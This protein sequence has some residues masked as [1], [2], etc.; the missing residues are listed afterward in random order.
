MYRD[1]EKTVPRVMEKILHPL[2]SVKSEKLHLLR[3]P[4][5]CKLSSSNGFTAPFGFLL[6]LMGRRCLSQL[7]V[8]GLGFRVRHMLEDLGFRGFKAVMTMLGPMMAYP[9]KY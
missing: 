2:Q 5:C 6:C 7:F 1:Y 3:A 4:G 8:F 9:M